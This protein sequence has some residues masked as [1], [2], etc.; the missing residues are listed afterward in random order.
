MRGPHPGGW[1]VVSVTMIVWAEGC[2]CCAIV[3][4]CMAL[5]LACSF[6]TD[7]LQSSIS[8]GG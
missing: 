7:V 5:V 3:Q 6:C 4:R 2:A 1:G 8:P